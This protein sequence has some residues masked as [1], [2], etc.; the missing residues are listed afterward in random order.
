MEQIT[1]SLSIPA[2]D[3]MQ[4]GIMAVKAGDKD[5]GRHLLTQAIAQDAQNQTAWLWLA[6]TT[7]DDQEK[8]TCLERVQAINPDTKAG[9]QARTYLQRHPLAAPHPASPPTTA[10]TTSSASAPAPAPAPAATAPAPAPAPAATAPAPAP[11]IQVRGNTR[12]LSLIAVLLLLLVAGNVYTVVT[13]YQQQ[14]IEVARAASYTERVATI[15]ERAEEQRDLIQL[16]MDSY[17]TEAYD[18]PRID[19]I[20]EQQLIATEHT[21]HALQII[22]IQ[23][24]QIIE[25]LAE[26]P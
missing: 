3:L 12:L 17:E 19:R 26:A 5:R 7:D 18:N 6:S 15:R 9:R 10:P 21:I 22:G 20:A 16:V 4:Q 24:S 23:N 13:T 1:M 8:Y 11:I 25:L 14:Q 2:D